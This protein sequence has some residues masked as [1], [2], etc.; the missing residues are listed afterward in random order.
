M[1]MLIIHL[2][3]ATTVDGIPIELVI[4]ARATHR[5]PPKHFAVVF[6]ENKPLENYPIPTLWV[7]D[8]VG[9]WVSI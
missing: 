8:G 5:A 3:E 4:Y 6:A 9:S 1:D 2:I 7:R